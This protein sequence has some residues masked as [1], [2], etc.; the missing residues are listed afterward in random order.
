MNG[1]FQLG[2]VRLSGVEAE[3][4]ADALII[5]TYFTGLDIFSKLVT[6]TGSN[7]YSYFNLPATSN[8]VTKAQVSAAGGRIG[9]YVDANH[10]E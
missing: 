10:C 5:D 6:T 8:G 9:S 7:P 2:A 3:V 1:F 4:A